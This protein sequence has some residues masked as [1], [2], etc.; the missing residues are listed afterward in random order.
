MPDALKTSKYVVAFI[1]V[2]G[3]KGMIKK[4]VDGSLNIVHRAYQRSIDF[5]EQHF[6]KTP[7]AV[8]IFSDNIIIGCRVPNNELL[9]RCFRAVNIMAA[10]VQG[11]FL[12]NGL[13]VRGGIAYGDFYKDD[14]MVWGSA[15]V[16]AYE[17]E[18]TMAF[19]P[20][21]I[22][23][24]DL[25]GDLNLLLEE[26]KIKESK[27]W[28]RADNDGLLYVDYLQE[29]YI[30]D[31]NMV[32]LS[33]LSAYDRRTIECEVEPKIMQKNI[34]QLNYVKSK[35]FGGNSDASNEG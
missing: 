28:L 33:E 15:L 7:F 22:I 14:I 31:Y 12:F 5:F 16:K 29:K 2:L 1:D 26:D 23:D 13:L 18:S 4:D 6:T 32:L 19:Y 24:P 9:L 34:W 11:N 35:L 10:M 20:R 21:V 25:V 30:K 3:A 27:L 8:H 17:L